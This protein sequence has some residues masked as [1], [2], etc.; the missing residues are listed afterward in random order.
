M[1]RHHQY[2]TNQRPTPAQV[3][4]HVEDMIRRFNQERERRSLKQYKPTKK[5]N[6]KDQIKAG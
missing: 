4:N 5:P 1:P 6:E 3:D 2:Q